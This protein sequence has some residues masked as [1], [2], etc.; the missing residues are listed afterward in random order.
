MFVIIKM[1]IAQAYYGFSTLTL[2]FFNTYPFTLNSFLTGLFSLG[3][4]LILATA[5]PVAN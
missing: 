3:G 5:Q 4:A 2:D 1:K